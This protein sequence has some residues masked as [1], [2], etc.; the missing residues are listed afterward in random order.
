MNSKQIMATKISHFVW[1][2]A[3][4]CTPDSEET[5]AGI[6][7]CREDT[8][9]VQVPV[10]EQVTADNFSLQVISPCSWSAKPKFR[11][12]TPSQALFF[13]SDLQNEISGTFHHTRKPEIQAVEAF[14]KIFYLNPTLVHKKC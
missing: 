3:F 11:N 12:F 9:Q 4:L 8:V 7:P 1:F 14:L 2:L 13:M 10:P 5:G 6:L